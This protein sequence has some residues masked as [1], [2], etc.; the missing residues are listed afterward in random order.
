M[1]SPTK[2]PNQSSLS[3]P[4]RDGLL[5]ETTIYLV[6]VPSHLPT[7]PNGRRTHHSTCLR[8][9]LRGIR[10][11]KLEA[12]RLGGRWVTSIEALGRFGNRVTATTAPTAPVP[13][14][15]AID[16]R[17]ACHVAKELDSAGI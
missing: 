13:S 17:R 9:V 14:S 6:D 4:A 7:S 12:V 2:S 15:S 3:P 1:R 11:V 16:R 5:G 10:G 8:W